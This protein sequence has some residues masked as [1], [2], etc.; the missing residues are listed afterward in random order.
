MHSGARMEN[1]EGVSDMWYKQCA[2]VGFLKLKGLTVSVTTRELQGIFG[3]VAYN[4]S[5]VS[6][7]FIHLSEE[8]KFISNKSISGRS[9]TAATD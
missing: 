5:T 8:R 2:V 9:V 1:S 4:K 3:Q 6:R 7:G